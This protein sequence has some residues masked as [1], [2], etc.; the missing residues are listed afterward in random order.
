VDPNQP[1]VRSLGVTLSGD[2]FGMFSGARVETQVDGSNPLVKDAD[3]QN[4][5]KG[6]LKRLIAQGRILYTEPHQKLET[7]DYFD[8][9]GQPYTGVVRWVDGQMTIERVP[10][11]S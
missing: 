8:Q 3:S 2:D 6:N 5:L 1:P 9:N 4:R 11:V 10:I 7:K